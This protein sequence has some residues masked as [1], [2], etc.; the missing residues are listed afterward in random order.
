MASAQHIRQ[1]RTSFLTNLIDLVLQIPIS[2]I[3]DPDNH[4][5]CSSLGYYAIYHGHNDM[6]LR[7]LYST[8][9]RIASPEYVEGPVYRHNTQH[10]SIVDRKIKVGFLSGFFYHH[11]VGLLMQGVITHLDRYSLY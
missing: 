6:L 1:V 11:S 2:S 10:S 5:G 9:M 7:R 8:V 4:L 3:P